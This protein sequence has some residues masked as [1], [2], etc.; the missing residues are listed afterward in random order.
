MNVP[1]NVRLESMPCPMGC[2]RDDEP[3]LRAGDRLHGLPGEFLVVRCA[4]CG[5]MR[6][7]PRP[8]PDTIGFYYPSDYS[9]YATSAVTDAATSQPRRSPVRKLLSRALRLNT[10]IVPDIAP[11]RLLEIGCA[12]GG[13]MAHMIGRG[14]RAQGIEFDA[15]A[16]ARARESGL[17]VQSSSI[18]EAKAPDAAVDLVIGWMV[19]EHLHSP[20]TSLRRLNEWTRPDGWLAISTPNA[21]SLDFRVFGEDGYALQLPTHLYHFTP[22]TVTAMLERAGWRV[23]RIFHQRMLG[24]YFGSIGNRMRRT[25]SSPALAERLRRLPERGGYFNHALLPLSMPLAALGQTGRMTIWA[26]KSRS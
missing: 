23:E 18:E 3:V 15:T 17:D 10:E 9:P 22:K 2:A 12:S 26:R 20:L 11:G 24:N 13:Y 4:T 19:L 14:W 8:T 6:T 7:D 16:A 25:G 5:L 1:E 21:A